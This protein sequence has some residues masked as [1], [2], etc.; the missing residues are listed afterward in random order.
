ML[1]DLTTRSPR[2]H[3]TP[4][5]EQKAMCQDV[6]AI[7][8]GNPL[9]ASSHLLNRMTEELTAIHSTTY[10]YARSTSRSTRDCCAM[11]AVHP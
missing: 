4:T 7:G 6:S 5:V 10:A 9:K 11:A 3:R 8:Y 1:W 2:T